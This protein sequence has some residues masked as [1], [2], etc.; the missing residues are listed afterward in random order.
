[1]AT[2]VEGKVGSYPKTNPLNIVFNRFIWTNG[3][4]VIG[5][6]WKITQL[7]FF[8]GL[9]YHLKERLDIYY[10]IKIFYR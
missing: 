10:L 8:F 5:V 7:T 3:K 1:M 9:S 4:Q 6:Q 2:I